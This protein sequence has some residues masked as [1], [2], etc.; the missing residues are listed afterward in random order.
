MEM[1]R[2]SETTRKTGARLRVADA[3]PLHQPDAKGELTATLYFTFEPLAVNSATL[4]LIRRLRYLIDIVL[5]HQ[6]PK[7]PTSIAKT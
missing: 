7:L 6:L 2:S 4:T 5:A 1:S 3:S